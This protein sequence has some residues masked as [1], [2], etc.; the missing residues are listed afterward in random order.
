MTR[1]SS[2]VFCYEYA[3]VSLNEKKSKKIKNIFGLW[4]KNNFMR[5]LLERD[6]RYK[7]TSKVFGYEH[8][9]VCR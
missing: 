9:S 1:R 5:S 4:H 8:L 7:N 6:S 3:I 2:A